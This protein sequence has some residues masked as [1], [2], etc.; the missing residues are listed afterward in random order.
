MDSTEPTPE[1]RRNLHADETVQWVVRPKATARFA[2]EMPGS[3]VGGVILGGI[4]GA[5]AYV[6]LTDPLGQ[7]ESTAVPIAAVLFV[8]GLALALRGPVLRLAFGTYEYAATDERIIRFEGVFGRRL[9]SIP[10][11]GVQDAQYDIGGIEKA[12]DV[13]TVSVDTERG[14]E[15]LSFPYADS[16]AEFAKSITSLAKDARDAP[17]RTRDATYTVSEDFASEAPAD[18]LADNLYPDEELQW[19]VTPNKTSRLL[20]NLPS[21]VVPSLLLGAIAGGAAGVA[22][23]LAT[24]GTGM[25]LTAGVGVG[26]VVCLLVAAANAYGHL[27][28]ATQYAATDRRIIEYENRWGRRFDSIPLAGVQ[29]AEYGVTFTENLFD[30]GSIHI[31]T[32]LGYET[33]VVADVDDPAGVAREI[34]QLATSDVGSRPVANLEDVSVGEGVASTEPTDDLLENLHDDER[35]LWTI[36]PDK[37]ARFLAGA[38]TGFP[39]LA[40]VALFLAAF[41]TVFAS[42]P[43]GFETAVLV[44]AAV[45]VGVFV[46]GY[47]SLIADYLFETTEYALT[48]DR[49]V[50]YSGRFGR[51]LEG[52][53]LS[54]VQDAEYRTDFVEDYF[55]VGDVTLDTD[56]GTE[57]M[58]LKAVANPQAVAREL[59]EVANANRYA[60]VGDD[61]GEE[62]AGDADGSGAGRATTDAA[63]TPDATG[64]EREGP[65][66]AVATK[67]CPSCDAAI[68]GTASFCTACGTEQPGRPTA[69]EADATCDA[70]GGP[71]LGADAYC[72]HCGTSTA[73]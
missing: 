69:A 33:L 26:A 18:G 58:T 59:S 16:P 12:F 22:S 56:R 62:D 17:E 23:V 71:G 55:D 14:Y 3:I 54:G 45:A 44:G 72:R 36:T 47:A 65:R 50:D 2:A 40:V 41:A 6:G 11:E 46:L 24:G 1:L 39:G 42:A 28:G 53:P 21:V 15:T 51:E 37:S 25:A 29:D 60:N 66:V 27:K 63:A 20:R 52:V 5:G 35:P 10:L 70:C 68:D 7:P 48:D 67:R 13:G 64:D 43:L 19:V 8:A 31:D 38:V 61:A 34:T 30:V 57:P 32:D 73:D 49:V 4:L 9:R